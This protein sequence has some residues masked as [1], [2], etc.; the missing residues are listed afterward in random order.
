MIKACVIR[1]KKSVCKHSFA[2][3]NEIKARYKM[4]VPESLCCLF[5]CREKLIEASVAGNF[6]AVGAPYRRNCKDWRFGVACAERFKEF[7][8]A[9]KEN[10]LFRVRPIVRSVSCGYKIGGEIRF[11][12]GKSRVKNLAS[13][14]L[15]YLLCLECFGKSCRISF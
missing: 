9:L 15:V 8:C 11:D 6:L 2:F 1:M 12:C 14:S 3:R 7:S 4:N 10:V 13:D 5:Y